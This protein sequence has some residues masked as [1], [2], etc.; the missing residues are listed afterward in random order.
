[1]GASEAMGR[2]VITDRLPYWSDIRLDGATL[3]YALGISLAA[4]LFAGVLPAVKAMGADVITTL[5]DEARGSSGLRIGRIMHGLVVLQIAFSLGL[6]VVTG[7]MAA[8]VR[9][10]KDVRFGFQPQ[11]TIT[12]QITLPESLDA[13][14]RARFQAALESR[15]RDD[16]GIQAFA[17]ASSLP[18]TRATRYRFALDGRE[19]A[20]ID[21]MPS[22]RRVAVSADFFATFGA[23]IARGRGFD[24]R[25]AA[26]GAPVAI[27]NERFAATAL[28]GQ[29]AIGHQIRFGNAD[30]PWRTIVGVVPDLW[31]GGLDASGDR[32][33]AG[34]YVPLAQAPPLTFSVAAVARTDGATVA[35]A[36]REATSAIDPDVPVYEVRTMAQVITDNSW[37]YGMGLVIVAACGIT[38]LVLA[39]IGL[40]GVIAF[41]VGRRTREFGI[42]MAVGANPGSIVR[43]VLSRGAL[44]V[45]IGLALGFALAWALARGIASLLFNV[46]PSDPMTFITFGAFLVFVTFAASL[47]PALRAAR[48]DPLAALRAD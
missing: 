42:R 41:S 22:V 34:V 30:E 28:A 24:T 9:N 33:P 31:V 7:L 16:P 38:A 48:V 37:F 6:L 17:V 40:Y 32:N 35:R 3:L 2:W 29:E 14:G 45:T 44:Q 18:A 47:I 25:D 19:Y 46:S 12:A 36:I 21:E 1:M 20:D 27:V 39:A 26:A 11:N 10:V 5:K 13:E 43:L 23:G 15:L 4:G 8:S